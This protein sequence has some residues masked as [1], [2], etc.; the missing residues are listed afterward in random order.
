MHLGSQA[1]F[2]LSQGGYTDEG[3]Q[4]TRSGYY[5]EG[6][7][8]MR[9]SA[10]SAGMGEAAGAT[11]ATLAAVT[12]EEEEEEEFDDEAFARR[13]QEEE[14]RAVMSRLIAAQL[15]M[16]GGYSGEEEEQADEEALED[17]TDP[18]QMTYEQLTALGEVVGT[19]QV[20]VSRSTLAALAEVTFVQTAGAGEEQCVLSLT[21]PK[22]LLALP[23]C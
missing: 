12:A 16:A 5:S 7:V 21:T 18:D 13:L 10:G 11:P 23:N 8:D 4:E 22:H 2:L 6:S 9:R 17:D 19:E 1:Y 3:G 15:G 14:Q 20:G